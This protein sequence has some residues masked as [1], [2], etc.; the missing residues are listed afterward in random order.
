MHHG[1]V[2]YLFEFDVQEVVLRHK[3]LPETPIYHF[4][5]DLIQGLQH[6]PQLVSGETSRKGYA[7]QGETGHED[8]K[9]LGD[10]FEF[11][12][13]QGLAVH[14]QNLFGLGDIEAVIVNQDF[15][16]GI[17]ELFGSANDSRAAGWV[18]LDLT[19]GRQQP[20]KH[21]WN[22][23]QG[24]GIQGDVLRT[25]IGQPSSLVV[26]GFLRIEYFLIVGLLRVTVKAGLFLVSRE[27]EMVGKGGSRKKETLGITGFLVLP[28]TLAQFLFSL[29]LDCAVGDV[30]NTS[31]Q[32]SEWSHHSS[33]TVTQSDLEQQPDR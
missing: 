13:L 10:G 31:A 25:A 19:M 32:K 29:F 26:Y 24:G 2:A 16:N 33:G 5:A 9:S 6:N 1:G 21:L 23:D 28:D 18:E 8:G 11:R 14:G 20:T 27:L 30:Q 3:T 7:L 15:V 12:D 4:R 22:M 17:L